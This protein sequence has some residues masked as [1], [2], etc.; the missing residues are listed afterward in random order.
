MVN[1]RRVEEEEEKHGAHAQEDDNHGQSDE[2]RG[3]SESRVGNGA[4]IFEL[5]LADNLLPALNQTAVLPQSKVSRSFRFHR[6]SYPLGLDEDYDVDDGEAER[7][8][9]PQ[10]A[11]RLGT[12]QVIRRVHL[13]R[14]DVI[15]V[16]HTLDHFQS[17]IDNEPT[18]LVLVN[19]I[20][21]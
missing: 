20:H 21:C 2:D 14:F 10:H 12:S 11:D 7:E 19:E 16:G 17:L 15:D 4:E 13:R 6:I 5:S 18:G 8:D 9:S 3:G 1:C